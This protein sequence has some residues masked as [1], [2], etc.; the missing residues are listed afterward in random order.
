MNVFLQI[1]GMTID[2]ALTQ[3]E[4]NDKKGAKIVKEVKNTIIWIENVFWTAQIILI[5]RFLLW[6]HMMSY[7]ICFGS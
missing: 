1:R 4:F 3:L 7:K 5:K 2:Q 6:K